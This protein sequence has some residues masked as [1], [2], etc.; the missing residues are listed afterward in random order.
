MQ[1]IV[2]ELKQVLTFKETTEV[3]DIALI[4]IKEPQMFVYAHIDEIERDVTRRDEWYHVHL[5]ILSIPL[6]KMQWTLRT[7]Q[8]TGQEIFTMG[9]EER[10]F[11]AVDLSDPADLVQPDSKK[12][13]NKITPLKRVK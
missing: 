13:N 8:I 10:F 5:T 9:G 6:Q 4:V 1:Q 2:D 12:E 11:K 7:E 3:G